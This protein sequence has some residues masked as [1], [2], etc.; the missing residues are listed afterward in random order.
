MQLIGRFERIGF[1]EK[2][3]PQITFTVN[4]IDLESVDSIKDKELVVEAKEKKNKRSRNANNYMWELLEQLSAKMKLDKYELYRYY[5]KAVG[6]CQQ[7]T[8]EKRASEMMKH[9][10]TEYGTGWLYEDVDTIGSDGIT[11][12]FYYGSSSYNTAQM[13]NLIDKVVQ[14][15]KAVGIDTLTPDQR[16]L[17]L[18]EWSRRKNAKQDSVDGQTHG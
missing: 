14:D 4:R 17:L 15:C 11:T 3:N 10:W 2:G 13:A 6:V 9:L 5:I 12:N 7:L 18:E 16:S 1:N 8:L